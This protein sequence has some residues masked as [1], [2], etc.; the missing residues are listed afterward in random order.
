ME[1]QAIRTNN[2]KAVLEL[3][4]PFSGKSVDIQNWLINW[5]TIIP[6]TGLNHEQQ[7]PQFVSKLTG[8]AQSWY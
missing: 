5:N 3:I 6:L 7:I 8:A 1:D 4:K 2:L